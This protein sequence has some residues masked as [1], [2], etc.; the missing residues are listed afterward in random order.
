[1]GVEFADGFFE[2]AGEGSAPSGVNGGDNALFGVN[3]ED[4]DAVG[5]LDSEEKAGGFGKRGISFAGFLRRR[6]KGP[7]DG[8]MDLFEDD[9][10]EFLSAKGGLEFLAVF[11]DVF[12]DVPVG[13]AEIE[14]G[15]TVEIGDA[16]GSCAETVEEPREFGERLK[17]EELEIASRF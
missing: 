4:G 13:E 6:F 3:E 2:D 10:R 9:E 5:G 15:V 11:E 16:A 14:D 12:A 17:L 8:R 1:M 7:D